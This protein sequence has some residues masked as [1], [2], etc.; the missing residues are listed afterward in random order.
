[1]KQTITCSVIIPCHRDDE[2]LKKAIESA[3]WAD[4]ILLIDQNSHIKWQD[5]T[6]RFTFEVLNYPQLDSFSAMKNMALKTVKTDW[7]FFLDSDEYIS[8]ELKNELVEAIASKKYDGLI[9]KRVDIFLGKKLKY[10][11]TKD[12]QFLRIVKKNEAEWRGTVHEALHLLRSDSAT[13]ILS[14]PLFHEPHTSLSQF[15]TKINVYTNLLAQKP[16]RLTILK[17]MLF[18]LGKFLYTFYFK[19]GFLDGY[20]GLIYSYC[21]S[22]HSSVVRIKRYEKTVE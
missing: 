10:G 9:L 4:Q 7:V 2:R 3:Q 15:L 19:L 18:P 16:E 8:E 17:S 6:K 1:M 22:I 13:K 5:L 21:M 12:A 20:R 14:S 11:E